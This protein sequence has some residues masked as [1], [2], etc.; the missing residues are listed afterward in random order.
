MLSIILRISR[1]AIHTPKIAP[2]RDRDTQ[3]GNRS[4]E[5]VAKSH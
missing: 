4:P 5:F 2:I 1:A 3:V